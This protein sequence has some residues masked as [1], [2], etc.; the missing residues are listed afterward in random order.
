MDLELALLEDA[1]RL[2]ELEQ[3][4]ALCTFEEYGG[5]RSLH[6]AHHFLCTGGGSDNQTIQKTRVS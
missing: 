1:E 3:V 6:V 4:S 5:C 2:S